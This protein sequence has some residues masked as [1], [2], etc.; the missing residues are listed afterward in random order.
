M[1]IKEMTME[2]V[3]NRRAAIAVEI[4]T[5]DKDGLTALNAE[6]DEL[7][8]RA[9]AIKAEREETR[10]A[11]AAVAAGAGEVVIK[12]QEERKKMNDRELRNTDEYVKAY[13][14][15]VKTGKDAECR[16][17]L[18]ENAP[19]NG[20]VPVPTFVEDYINTAWENDEILSRVRKTYF[21]GNV[22][23]GFEING[24]EAAVHPEGS[25]DPFPE[26]EL[27]LGVVELIPESIKKWITFSDEAL[28][29]RGRAF[30]D[31]L[32]DEIAYKITKKL[33]DLVVEDIIESPTVATATEAAVSEITAAPSVTA[34]AQAISQL[35]DEATDVVVIINK[36]TYAD[37]KAAQAA[38][39]FSVDPF[40]G[41]P[42]IF[43]NSIDAYSAATA[44]DP[45][46]IV[47]DLRG[48][49]V[50][51]PEG[52]GIAFKY[53]DLSLAE[54]DLVKIVGREYAAHGVVANN[55]FCVINKPSA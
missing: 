31:Y 24:D 46:A 42:V 8:S 45:Y 14:N 15:F 4:E 1:S 6:L 19:A 41:R 22:K 2:E 55:R 7:E 26:E 53:D 35:S 48:V 54:K 10:A 34:V 51:F 27:T 18:T 17:L 36:Q 30:V 29:M 25:T 21:K 39:N 52:E 20:Q 37:F 50:N 32:Y 47:G 23:I 28:D 16:A 12:K 40:D 11:A 5:A 33:A 13:I 3:E 43:N 44:G 9:A 49:Q 38:G